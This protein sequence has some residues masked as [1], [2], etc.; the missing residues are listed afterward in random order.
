MPTPAAT[1]AAVSPQIYPMSRRK[2]PPS[3]PKQT[4]SVTPKQTSSV[5]LPK[6]TSSVT[7]PKQTSSVTLPKQTSS[8]TP[9]NKCPPST[10]S[11]IPCPPDQ[12]PYRE[13]CHFRGPAGAGSL[14]RR[15]GWASHPSKKPVQDNP[16]DGGGSPGPAEALEPAVLPVRPKPSNRQSSRSGRSPRTG[17]PRGPAEA[18]EPAVLPK[19]HRHSFIR[20]VTGCRL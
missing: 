16:R 4:S 3:P 10:S 6:Q 7:L 13:T 1:H 9:R 14:P 2:R 15:I 12:K 5:T 17:S 18:L 8:V 11:A 19:E 20:N